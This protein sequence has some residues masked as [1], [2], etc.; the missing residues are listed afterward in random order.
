MTRPLEGKTVLVTGGARGIGRAICERLA[1][2]GCQV[3]IN[4]YN[5]S[6]EAEALVKELESS[7]ARAFAV[8]ANVSDPSAIAPSTPTPAGMPALSSA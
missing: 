4:Y 7:G 2:A 5:S 1:R 6:D 3:S 8:Q